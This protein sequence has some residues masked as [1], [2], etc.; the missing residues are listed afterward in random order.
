MTQPLCCKSIRDV[1]CRI[2]RQVGNEDNLL[3]YNEVNCV[4]KKWCGTPLIETLGDGTELPL[5]QQSSGTRLRQSAQCLHSGEE[6][7]E[8]EGT[9]ASGRVFDVCR[10]PNLRWRE[11]IGTR[12]GSMTRC[13]SEGGVGK[14]K[15]TKQTLAEAEST[16]PGRDLCVMNLPSPEG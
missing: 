10:A 9:H 11:R 6:C 8:S 4:N 3:K 16:N 12:C 13:R 15:N 7:H 14:R 2:L 1:Q 5:R